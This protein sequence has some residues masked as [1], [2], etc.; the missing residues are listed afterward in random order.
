MWVCIVEVAGMSKLGQVWLGD[1]VMKRMSRGW[2]Y[3][4]MFLQVILLYNS[5]ERP[6]CWFNH[7]NTSRVNDKKQKTIGRQV[8]WSDSA[9]RTGPSR[10][11]DFDNLLGVG[12]DLHVSIILALDRSINLVPFV[13]TAWYTTRS[14]L[15][16]KVG[17]Q[18]TRQ[19]SSFLT[20]KSAWSEIRDIDS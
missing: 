1:G 14:I 4:Y 6:R 17:V 16:I 3:L 8:M 19:K 9:T 10:Y 13:H 18:L 2:S 15:C 5:T 7:I 11:L 12:V 20:L